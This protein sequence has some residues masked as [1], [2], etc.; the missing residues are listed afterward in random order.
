M[1]IAYQTVAHVIR[2]NVFTHYQEVSACC[3]LLMRRTSVPDTSLQQAVHLMMSIQATSKTIRQNMPLGIS[4][5]AASRI[6]TSLHAASLLETCQST[7]RD[8][9]ACR[10]LI[11][12]SPH[13]NLTSQGEHM[14]NRS[15]RCQCMS[16]HSKDVNTCKLGT[17]TSTVDIMLT[18]ACNTEEH[19]VLWG[20]AEG[21]HVVS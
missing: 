7:T 3:C 9:N 5:H 11:R 17:R 18:R 13:Q 8:A 14:L 12:I 10:F 19:W 1:V 20:A 4:M 21:R 16:V 15:L 6:M 2:H